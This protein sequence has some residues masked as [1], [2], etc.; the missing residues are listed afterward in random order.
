MLSLQ[1]INV[2]EAA[3]IILPGA[4]SGPQ[5]KDFLLAAYGEMFDRDIAGNYQGSA[6][7]AQSLRDAP[8]ITLPG[9]HITGVRHHCDSTHPGQ[10]L[11]HCC[12]ACVMQSSGASDGKQTSQNGGNFVL[13]PPK[14][15]RHGN[16]TSISH[17]RFSQH[18]NI[19]VPCPSA[20][21]QISPPTRHLHQQLLQL[22]LWFTSPLLLRLY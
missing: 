16:T 5:A 11:M 10:L 7:L 13:L 22:A 1:I 4:N 8:R 2:S 18:I 14:A 20:F 15:P 17:R 6:A 3:R 21:T 12:D 9:V 19:N